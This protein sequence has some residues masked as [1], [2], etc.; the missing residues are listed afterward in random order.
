MRCPLFPTALLFCAAAAGQAPAA[1]HYVDASSQNPLKPFQTWAT[2]ATNLGA[3]LAFIT[4]QT[5]I[6]GQPG[7]TMFQD[8]N[9]LDSGPFFYRAGVQ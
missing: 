7:V 4:I 6:S 3:Q 8:T 5:N 9:A 2:A 1:V